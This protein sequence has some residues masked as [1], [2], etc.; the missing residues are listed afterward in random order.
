LC[1]AIIL[2]I[3][4]SGSFPRIPYYYL[5]IAESK[6]MA[7]QS[8]YDRA[9]ALRDGLDKIRQKIMGPCDGCSF[10]KETLESHKSTMPSLGKNELPHQRTKAQIQYFQSLLSQAAA[11]RGVSSEANVC[12]SSRVEGQQRMQ[13][14]PPSTPMSNSFS[15]NKSVETSP[16]RWEAS[17]QTDLSLNVLEQIDEVQRRVNE[18]DIAGARRF[19]QEFVQMSTAERERKQVDAMVQ[20]AKDLLQTSNDEFNVY[21]EAYLHGVPLEYLRRRWTKPNEPKEGNGSTSEGNVDR[22][23]IVVTSPTPENSDIS[24]A[25]H[26]EELDNLRNEELE[27]RKEESEALRKEEEDL[28]QRIAEQQQKEAVLTE[29]LTSYA[30]VISQ[31]TNYLVDTAESE[32]LSQESLSQLIGTVN[33]LTEMLNRAGIHE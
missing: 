23:E 18:N 21:H 16:F 7:E 27:V 11:C 1:L 24:D 8:F 25:S 31:L 6:K 15:T 3:V 9:M 22:V 32:N 14:L 10:L 19:L 2:F 20:F 5:E 13:D 33:G 28:R 29:T 26:D 4:P 12:S 30:L 17:S